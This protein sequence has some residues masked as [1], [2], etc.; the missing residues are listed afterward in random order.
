MREFAKEFYL[1]PAWRRAREYVFRRDAGLCVE[2][3]DPGEIVHHKTPLTPENIRDP[4]V[5][6]G[7]DNLELLCRKCHGLKHV[8]DLPAD[9]ALIFDPE[10]NLIPRN[11]SL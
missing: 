2:C 8:T 4:S 11:V 1:S 10:G 6:L 9:S 3:G 5:S 7:E